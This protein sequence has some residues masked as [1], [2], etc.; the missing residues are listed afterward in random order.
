MEVSN[1]PLLPKGLLKNKGW[2][3]LEKVA[4]AE[5]KPAL[6]VILHL[7]ARLLPRRELGK[8]EN[9]TQWGV[10]SSPLG[11]SGKAVVLRERSIRWTHP[12]PKGDPTWQL[13]ASQLGGREP[14]WGCLSLAPDLKAQEKEVSSPLKH[15]VIPVAFWLWGGREVLFDVHHYKSYQT[16]VNTGLYYSKSIILMLFKKFLNRQ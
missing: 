3:P 15:T 8:R 2:I 14:G 16:N 4:S 13:R 6:Q 11:G 12:D 7:E 9:D 5:L 10:D 1:Q